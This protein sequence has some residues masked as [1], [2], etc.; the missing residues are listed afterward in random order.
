MA[1]DP[2]LVPSRAREGSVSE[3]RE[4]AHCHQNLYWFLGYHKK[5]IELFNCH[6]FVIFYFLTAITVAYMGFVFL[7]AIHRDNLFP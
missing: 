4:L 2:P 3:R 7:T 1:I 5:I 6:Q